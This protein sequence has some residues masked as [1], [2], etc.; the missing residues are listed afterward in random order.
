L[1]TLNRDS[2]S[3]GDDPP[4]TGFEKDTAPVDAEQI[5]EGHFEDIPYPISTNFEAKENNLSICDF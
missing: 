2:P 5:F 4:Y 3:D 1:F